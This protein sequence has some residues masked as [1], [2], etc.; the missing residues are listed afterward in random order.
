MAGTRGSKAFTASCCQLLPPPQQQRIGKRLL[1]WRHPG[2]N[3]S[4]RQT[5]ETINR[6]LQ[7]PPRRRGNLVN[8]R[9]VTH[10]DQTECA[11]TLSLYRRIVFTRIERRRWPEPPPKHLNSAGYCQRSRGAIDKDPGPPRYRH[12][13]VMV[14]GSGYV[15]QPLGAPRPGRDS[16]AGSLSRSK[17]RSLKHRPPDHQRPWLLAKTPGQFICWK[18]S[19]LTPPPASRGQSHGKYEPEPGSERHLLPI[20]L[21]AHEARGPQRRRSRTHT[22]PAIHGDTGTAGE[23]GSGPGTNAHHK[24]D[25]DQRRQRRQQRDFAATGR[26]SECQRANRLTKAAAHPGRHA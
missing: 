22:E 10:P 4:R 7:R 16:E 18:K 5:T 2:L 3:L 21:P 14:S 8:R 9:P 26:S 19:R 12:P 25:G 17:D 6:R 1:R 15:Q 11:V 20:S 24:G 23:S 13:A